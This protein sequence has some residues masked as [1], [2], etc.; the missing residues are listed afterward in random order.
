MGLYGERSK[1]VNITGQIEKFGRWDVMPSKKINARC[2][3]C[4][5]RIDDIPEDVL[6]DLKFCGQ[7]GARLGQTIKSPI[8]KITSRLRELIDDRKAFCISDA[9][10][11]E[12]YEKDIE[13][14]TAAIEVLDMSAATIEETVAHWDINCDGYYPFCSHCGEATQHMTPYCGNCGAKMMT[15][16]HE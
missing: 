9:E 4:G 12:I 1:I 5:M 6:E 11:D 14:L 3:C 8:V 16:R 7:C 10:H 15:R 13:A 2:S